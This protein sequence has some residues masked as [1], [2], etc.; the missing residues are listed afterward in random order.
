[1]LEQLRENLRYRYP[2]LQIAGSYS[3]PFH[4]ISRE[5]DET[6]IANINKAGADFVWVGL[7]APKQERWMASHQGKI[8]GLMVGVGAGFDYL[9]GNIKRA[10]K[11]MQENNLEWFYRLMQEPVRLFGRYW[12][13]NR[14]FIWNAYIKGK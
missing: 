2:D 12:H 3:P 13:T 14:K 11:W 9:A 6:I 7:G 5:E 4:P 1:T 10:P 8:H